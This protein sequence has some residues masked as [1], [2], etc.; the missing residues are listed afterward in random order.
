MAEN[1]DNQIN[2]KDLKNILDAIFE[3]ITNDLK[4]ASVSIDEKQDF[5]WDLPSE[6]LFKVNE[7]APKP[8]VG[9]LSD[10]W[11][12]L[13]P[14]IQDKEQAFSLMLIHVAPL[15]RWMGEKIGQ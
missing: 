2:L 1:Q 10:D 6:A 3:H 11:E 8:D 12:F 14:L 7:V 13:K 9:R 4:I 5:Y 15:L